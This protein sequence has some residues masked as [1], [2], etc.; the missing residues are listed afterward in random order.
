MIQTAVGSFLK[1][2]ESHELRPIFESV[3]EM[4][5]WAGLYNLT[6]AN[7]GQELTDAGLSPL[8]AQELVT[9]R[10]SYLLLMMGMICL[11]ILMYFLLLLPFLWLISE[12]LMMR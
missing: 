7:L 6:T 11:N 12:S 9:V 5:K 2:Y 1:Y 8:L 3:E 4:L 10:N